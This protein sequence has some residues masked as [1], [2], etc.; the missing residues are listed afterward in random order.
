MQSSA[1][2][3]KTPKIYKEEMVDCRLEEAEFLFINGKE[4]LKE[5]WYISGFNRDK[6]IITQNGR[7]NTLIDVRD[8]DLFGIKPMRMKKIDPIEFTGEI[9]VHSES[10]SESHG[11]NYK[12]IDDVCVKLP[13]EYANLIGKKVNVTV[14]IV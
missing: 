9:E 7:D 13:S 12:N 1:L 4:I 14:E 11:M 8:F 10:F 6:V 3:E 5:S 2:E